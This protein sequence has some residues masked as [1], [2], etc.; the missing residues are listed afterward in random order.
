MLQGLSEDERMRMEIAAKKHALE[1]DEY[2]PLYPDVHDQSLMAAIR[3]EARLRRKGPQQSQPMQKDSKLA[4]RPLSRDM[5]IF[6]T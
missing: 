3:V 4:V 6:E 2:Y 1:V 5:R